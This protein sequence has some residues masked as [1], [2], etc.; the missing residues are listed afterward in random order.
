M[1][2]KLEFDTTNLNAALSGLATITGKTFEEVVRNEAQ[3]I[4]TKA[5]QKTPA[6]SIE[7]I[8]KRAMNKQFWNIDGKTYYYKNAKQASAI[9]A[10]RKKSI[11]RRKAARGLAKKGWVQAAQ[12]LGLPIK[13]IPGYVAKAGSR[14]GQKDYPEDVTLTAI[15]EKQVFE[16][17]IKNKRTYAKGTIG[18]LQSAIYGR[19]KYF[20]INCSK[21]LQNKTVEFAQKYPGLYAE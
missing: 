4:L 16:L 1:S 11:K 6:A 7:S 20:D 8:T 18:A 13:K 3:A 17:E 10:A 5:M 9:E 19:I 21:V 14:G 15:G 2:A 12:R